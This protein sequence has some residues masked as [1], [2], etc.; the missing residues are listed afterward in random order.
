MSWAGIFILLWIASGCSSQTLDRD[1]AELHMQIGTG[2]L[3]KGI[4]PQ[5]L[6]ELQKAQQL[7]PDNPAI[8]NN[9]GLVYFVRGYYAEAEKLIRKALAGHPKYSDARNNLARVLLEQKR[10]TE[11]FAELAMVEKDL[12]YPQLDKMWL[13]YGIGHYRQGSYVSAKDALLNSLKYNR[14]NC[15]ANTYYG[16]TLYALRQY[17]NAAEALDAAIEFCEAT[18]SNE[19]YYFGGQSYLRLGQTERALARF[20]E[21]MRLNPHGPH[22]AEV[23][24]LI[25]Q[26]K[27]KQ[28]L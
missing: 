9:L 21:I 4:Y 13:N 8:L 14:K 1:A 2:Y 19:A 16:Q 18:P 24:T 26:L 17:Q 6:E 20:E 3:A 22:G 11:A 23:R 25:H 28:K 12:T 10:F 15:L 5:A 7:D 27:E